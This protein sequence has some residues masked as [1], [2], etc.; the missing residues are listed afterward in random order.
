MRQFAHLQSQ[1]MR[2]RSALL[3]CLDHIHENLT[4]VKIEMA[5]YNKKGWLIWCFHYI[6]ISN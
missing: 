6:N 4:E 5:V 2:S 1:M 3:E